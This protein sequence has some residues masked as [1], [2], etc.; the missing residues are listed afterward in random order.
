MLLVFDEKG[1]ADN[2][3]LLFNH[4]FYS[5]ISRTVIGRRIQEIPSALSYLSFEPV[6]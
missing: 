5:N 1:G 2:E 6:D 4:V 3:M